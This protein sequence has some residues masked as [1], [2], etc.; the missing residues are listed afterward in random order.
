V[1]EYYTPGPDGCLRYE[2]LLSDAARSPEIEKFARLPDEFEYR[3]IG[4][5]TG[6]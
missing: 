1:P 2:Q 4:A 3:Y 5:G 6:R